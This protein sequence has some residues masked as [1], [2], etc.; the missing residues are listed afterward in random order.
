MD[1]SDEPLARLKRLPPVGSHLELQCGDVDP[2]LVGLSPA[3]LVPL[4]V[5][6]LQQ[7]ERRLD[8][9]EESVPVTRRTAMPGATVLEGWYPLFQRGHSGQG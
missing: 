1:E 3:C 5:R 7:M 6:W 9:L 8:A 2:K 4:V